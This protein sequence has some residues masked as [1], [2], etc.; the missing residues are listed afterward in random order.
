MFQRQPAAKPGEGLG[1]LF[2]G[3]IPNWFKFGGHSYWKAMFPGGSPKTPCKAFAAFL[4]ADH[5]DPMGST[6]A[7]T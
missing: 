7:P 5:G 4:T 3:V 1:S 2:K 6:G